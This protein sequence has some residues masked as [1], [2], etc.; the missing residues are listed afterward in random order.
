MK[1]IKH[2]TIVNEIVDF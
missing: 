2:N 1:T